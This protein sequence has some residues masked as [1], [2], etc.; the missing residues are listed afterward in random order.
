[1]TGELSI[2]GVFVPT[3]LLVAIAALVVSAAV[4]RLLVLTGFYRF[5]TYKALVDLAVFIL[6]LGGLSFLA[7]LSGLQP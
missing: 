1:M 3:L 4:T 6:I 5:V 2:G 7:T